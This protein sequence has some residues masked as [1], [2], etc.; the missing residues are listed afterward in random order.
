MK[1]TELHPTNV[2]L[3]A[4]SWGKFELILEG[5]NTAGT[6]TRCTVLMDWRLWP[7]VAIAAAKAWARERCMRT[8]EMIAIE[9]A[10]PVQ[11]RLTQRQEA[12]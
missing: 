4:V 3:G 11:A 9:A 5:I 6:W 12:A 8:E 10:L 1:S 2:R 7:M